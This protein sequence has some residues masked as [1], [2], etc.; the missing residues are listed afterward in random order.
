VVRVRKAFKVTLDSLDHL[1]S[2]DPL[3]QQAPGEVLEK[4]AHQEAK[5]YPDHK[6]LKAKLVN[7]DRLDNLDPQDNLV[8]VEALVSQEIGVR[9]VHQGQLVAQGPLGL[10]DK[11]DRKVKRV[12]LVLLDLQEPQGKLVQMVH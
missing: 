8:K 4:Q 1:D 3:D 2:L 7:P 9:E 11:Q 12:K 5:D 6:D 10:L